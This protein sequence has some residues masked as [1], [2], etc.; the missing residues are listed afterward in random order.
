MDLTV[1]DPQNILPHQL[2]QQERSLLYAFSDVEKGKA[3]IHLQTKE[4]TK[5]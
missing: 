3:Y 4:I 5:L 2:V 1:D